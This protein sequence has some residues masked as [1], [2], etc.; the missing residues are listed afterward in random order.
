MKR[1]NRSLLLA[2]CAAGVMTFAVQATAED[3]P[4]PSGGSG[5]TTTV[6]NTNTNGIPDLL[7]TCPVSGEKLNGEMGAPYVFSYQGQEV[8]LCCKGC[9]KDFDKNPQKYIKLIRAADKKKS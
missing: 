5:I 4:M 6:A 1:L 9:K 7:K 2:A 3:S 8:K